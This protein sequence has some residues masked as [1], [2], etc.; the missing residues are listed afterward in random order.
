MIKI[1]N[2]EYSKSIRSYKKS[3]AWNIKR[4]VS[5]SIGQMNNRS[6]VLFHK[7]TDFLTSQMTDL[8]VR[9]SMNG[10]FKLHAAISSKQFFGLKLHF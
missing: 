2:F 8:E 10:P 1:K 3:N 7:L 6:I 9:F 5:G 4:L